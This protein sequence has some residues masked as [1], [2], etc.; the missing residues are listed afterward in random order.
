MGRS[1][2]NSEKRKVWLER[3]E[4]ALCV[5]SAELVARRF[6]LTMGELRDLCPEHF[7][8][9]VQPQGSGACGY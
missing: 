7:V 3:I 9:D 2:M 1:T 4:K 5:A 6:K 8:D